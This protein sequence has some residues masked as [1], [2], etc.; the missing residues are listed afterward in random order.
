MAKYLRYFT[1]FKSLEGHTIRAEIY[2]ESATAFTPVELEIGTG[3]SPLTIEW[4]ETNKIEPIQGSTATLVVN[5]SSDRQLLHLASAIAPGEVRMD[6]YR[7]GVLWWSGTLDGEGYEEPYTTKDNYDVMLTFSDFGVLNR[8]PWS[9]TGRESYNTIL[10]ACITA[11][12]FLYGSVHQ[13]I[14]TKLSNGGMMALTSLILNNDNFYDEESEAMTCF[15]VLK[16]ILQPF[17]LRIIQRVGRIIIYDLNAASSLAAT[18]VEWQGNDASLS[19]DQVFNDAVITFSPYANDTLAE[20]EVSD[21]NPSASHTIR[22]SYDPDPDNVVDGFTLRI[23]NTAAEGP[24]LENGASF[25]DIEAIY[26]GSDASGIIWSFA[27]RIHTPTG[28]VYSQRI[29]VPGSCFGN[30][31]KDTSN[32]IGQRIATFSSQY[33]NTPGTNAGNYYKLRINLDLLLDVRYNPFED[34]G[35]YNEKSD[36][37]NM[38][39]KFGF[40]YV[41]MMVTLR[42]APGGNALYH[43]E[44]YHL[45]LSTKISSEYNE[46]RWVS[47][48]GSPGCFFLAYYDQ[49]D[50]SGKSGVGGWA[51]NRRCIGRYVKDLPSSWAKMEQ[52]EYVPL[53]PS[54][55]YLEVTLYSGLHIRNRDIV[56]SIY[57]DVRWLAYKDMKISLIKSN[58][59]STDMEDQEDIAHIN[60][61]AQ[62]HFSI[63]TILGTLSPASSG[64]NGRGVILAG[65]SITAR[66]LIAK[67]SATQGQFQRAGI[68]DRLEKLLLGTIYSQYAERKI[69]LSGT[70]SLV[71]GFVLADSPRIT[72]KFLMVADTQDLRDDTS[73]ITMTEFGPD[74]YTGIDYE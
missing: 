74:E 69:K 16:G 27:E 17:A 43:L 54:G 25:F 34:A 1:Q 42:D 4:A 72:G 60:A 13:N 38:V 7:D 31:G 63:D 56:N 12:G 66:G 37:S 14:S 6:V 19:H 36:Y 61:N 29:R 24:V 45:A 39:S 68:T 9:R 30:D 46:P 64:A 51:T 35:D 8:I 50:R 65:G 20:G 52:G 62:E 32:F 40:V 15:D 21:V 49:E 22:T 28:Y 70:V 2:Q 5:S 58:G 18:D 55:G 3:E 23:G 59:K 71:L 26:S 57:D 53:P 44:N 47:G 67:D 41:P 73:M 11:A 10:N 48:A 33:V